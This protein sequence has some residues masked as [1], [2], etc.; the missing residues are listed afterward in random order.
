MQEPTLALEKEDPIVVTQEPVE[1][2]VAMVME[3]VVPQEPTQKIVPRKPVKHRKRHFTNIISGKLHMK[4][5][6]FTLQNRIVN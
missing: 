3:I 5:S 1:S 2:P 6:Y 4:P